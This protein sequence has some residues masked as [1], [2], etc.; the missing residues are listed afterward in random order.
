M[1]KDSEKTEPVG[2]PETEFTEGGDK[3]PFN[4]GNCVHMRAGICN[5]PTM[6]EHSKQPR[7]KRGFPKVDEDDCCKFVRR[8]GDE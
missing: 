2:E 5:H 1:A 6:I 8:P 7:N 3:G 4:C